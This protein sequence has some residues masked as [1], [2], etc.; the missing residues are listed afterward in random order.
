MSDKLNSSLVVAYSAKEAE[1]MFPLNW[2]HNAIAD[3]EFTVESDRATV[4]KLGEVA[5]QSK[6]D[7]LS[8]EGPLSSYRFYLAGRAQLL[9]LK[10]ELWDV[11]AFLKQFRFS[12]LEAAAKDSSSMNGLICAVFAG[13]VRLI[14]LLVEAEADVNSRVHGLDHFGYFD[15]QTLLMAAAKSHQSATVLSELIALRGDVNK[16]ASN[17]ANTAFM[18]RSPEQVHTVVAARAEIHRGGLPLGLSPLT[19]VVSFAT[20]E[21]VAAMLA[22]RSDPNPDL[23]G[24]GYSPLHGIAFFS[25]SNKYAKEITAPRR[26]NAF[27]AFHLL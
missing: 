23:R 24:L 13:D 15:G 18:L 6:I 5:V 10:S 3:G 25:R 17:G 16:E 4:I 22:A 26:K 9:G 7:H 2:Q 12:S 20:V 21:T 1:Y 14:R 19:G 8:S 27:F 11:D